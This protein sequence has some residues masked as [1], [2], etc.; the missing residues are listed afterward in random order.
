MSQ[1]GQWFEGELLYNPA[2]GIEEAALG[3]LLAFTLSQ[4][5]AWIY[6]YTHHGLSYSRAFVQSIILLS[7][8]MHRR[9]W[10]RARH[11]WPC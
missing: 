6:V 2:L 4:I 8:I 11:C 3:I 10:K 7:V 9:S 5:T 1:L